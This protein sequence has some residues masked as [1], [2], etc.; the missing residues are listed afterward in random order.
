MYAFNRSNN[1]NKAIK[2]GYL[3]DVFS[4]LLLCIF[5][6]Y[7]II[8]YTNGE[9]VFLTHLIYEHYVHLILFYCIFVLLFLHILI[10]GKKKYETSYGLHT[11][12]TK[13][14]FLQKQRYKICMFHCNQ[15]NIYNYGEDKE[16]KLKA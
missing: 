11:L 6:I 7:V 14:R 3:V 5:A 10:Q 2:L 9:I 12:K 13:M 4:T 1:R 16:Q 8:Y 15:H